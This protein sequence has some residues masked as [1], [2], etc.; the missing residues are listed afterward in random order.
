[1]DGKSVRCGRAFRPDSCPVE[2][3]SPS[4]AM[5][6][7]R[8]LRPRL[9][10]TEGPQNS[11]A[12]PA[13]RSNSQGKATAKAKRSAAILRPPVSRYGAVWPP[14]RSCRR[15]QLHHPRHNT[16]CNSGGLNQAISLG[17]LA[18][19]QQRKVARAPAGVR[20]HSVP[21][22]RRPKARPRRARLRNRKV[23]ASTAPHPNPPSRG[24]REKSRRQKATETAPSPSASN[25]KRSEC[26]KPPCL[27]AGAAFRHIHR[28]A[29]PGIKGMAGNPF[30]AP[31]V[32]CVLPLCLRATEDM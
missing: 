25:K 28:A 15:E 27:P 21:R 30:M 23:V 17:H 9:T 4:L 12:L 14:R 32:V 18:L 29:R 3:A 19:G 13:R 8:P 1:M 20:N 24:K 7:A 26:E 10:A 11:S 5:P 16:A 22:G 31:Q 6:A 2:K